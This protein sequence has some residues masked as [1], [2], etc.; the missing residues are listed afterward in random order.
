M[1]HDEEQYF[2]E[3]DDFESCRQVQSDY[4]ALKI[5]QAAKT[6]EAF[7]LMS[8]DYKTIKA[9]N[10]W[11]RQRNQ[12]LQEQLDENYRVVRQQTGDILKTLL[13]RVETNDE[14][15]ANS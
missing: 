13:Y 5:N 10:R 11:L 14:H 8:E 7:M 2:G 9:E 15:E 4:R 12:E 3:N 1:F 6:I